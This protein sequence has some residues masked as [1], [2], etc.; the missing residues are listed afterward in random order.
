MTV[1]YRASPARAPAW[2]VLGV[3]LGIP[4][5]A[6]ALAVGGFA[7]FYQWYLPLVSLALLFYVWRTSGSQLQA[8]LSGFVWGLGYFLTGVSW[9]F[10]SMHTYGD[11]PAV[12]AAI[13]TFAFCAYLAAFPAL[14]GWIAVRMT[15]PGRP[16]LRLV[17]AAAAM[18]LTEWIRGWLLTGFPWLGLGTSQVPASPFVHWAPYVGTYGVTLLMCVAAAAI[19]MPSVARSAIRYGLLA[20]ASVMLVIGVLV[21]GVAWTRPAGPP[22]KV[23]LLQ[24]NVPQQMKWEEEMRTRTLLDYRRMIFEADAPVVVIPETALPAFLDQLPHD[25]LQSLRDHAR[26]KGKDLVIGTAEREPPGRDGVST[27]YYNSLVLLAAD[28]RQASF[29][30][31]HLV[32]FGEFV[33]W[34]FRWFVDAMRIPMGDFTRGAKGQAPLVAHGIPFGVAICYEDIFGEEMIEQLPAARAFVNVS[35]DAW[36]GESWAADQHLQASQMRALETGRWMVRS[37]NTGASAAIDPQG[38]VVKRL[39]P[40]AQ[41]TLYAEVTPMDG[42]TP[43][44]RFGNYPAV[45]VALVLLAVARRR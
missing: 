27:E 16:E 33:P 40:F 5:V 23:A 11:M 17:A 22:V 13:A 39:P 14:A 24:G 32:P 3:G 29:R 8:A 38:R 36:F 42:L 34:G 12:M 44:A 37:T 15:A 10:V 9:V 25:Y 20:A 4:L 19:A 18:T 6:G 41:G 28:G 35:N 26:A 7:P 31:R 1:E 43:Y 2:R 30:K 45:L 21:A